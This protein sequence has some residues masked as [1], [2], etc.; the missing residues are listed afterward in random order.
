VEGFDDIVV[1][2]RVEGFDAVIL[3]VADADHQDG[4]AREEAAQLSADVDS[5]A[6]GNGTRTGEIDVEKDGFAANDASQR[7]GFVAR[8]SF[9]DIEALV[10]KSYVKSAA[11]RIVVVDNQYPAGRL[12]GVARV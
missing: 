10:V 12:L 7:E 1:G 4:E 8:R 6:A 5:V 2:A 11:N 9:G 3:A